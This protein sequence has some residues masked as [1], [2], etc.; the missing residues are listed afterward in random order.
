MNVP[1]LVGTWLQRDSDWEDTYIFHADGTGKLISGAEY[2]FTYSV[3]GDTL[4]L[5][6]GPDDDEDFTFSVDG[7][8]LILI[9]LWDEELLLDKQA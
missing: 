8:L 6:Y 2:P 1:E 4:T 5:T 7:D 3:S 9:D